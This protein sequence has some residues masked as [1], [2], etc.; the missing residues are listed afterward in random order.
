MITV[1][2]RGLRVEDDRLT[3][4]WF[5]LATPQG[6]RYHTVGLRELAAVPID[7][8]EDPDVL[9]KQ[10]AAV[11][12]MYN[13]EVDFLYAA[14]GIFS[15]DHIGIV[16]FY[17]A[18][19]DGLTE[20]DAAR[21]ALTRLAAVEATLA[22]Y[23]QSKIV[24]PDLRWVQWYL[25]FVAD[26]S[27]NL[28]AIL[29]HPDPRQGKRGL[30]RE[31][32]LSLQEDDDLAAQQNELLFRGLAKLREDFVFQVTA[33]RVG[34][35]RLAHALTQIA[36]VASNVAS[37]RR[38]QISIGLSIGIPLLAAITQGLGGGHTAA[39]SRAHASGDTISEGWGK[40]HTDSW[41]HT[42]SHSISEGGAE[43]WGE[44]HSTSVSHGVTDSAAHTDS[45]GTAHTES[46]GTAHTETHGTAATES[47]ATTNAAGSS[48][49][50]GG[51]ESHSQSQGH[52][53]S[54]AFGRGWQTS[55]GMSVAEGVNTSEGGSRGVT[56]SHSVSHSQNVGGS[57][58]AAPLGIGASAS[59]GEGVSEGIARAEML[60]ENWSAGASEMNTESWG[61]GSS[62]QRTEGVADSV[63][64]V[65][66]VGSSWSAGG[67]ES[68]SETHSTATT[69][70]HSASDTVSKG[71]ADT[72]SKGAADTKGQAISVVE[73][74]SHMNSHSISRTWG[75]AWGEA[76]T[77]GGAD[78][79]SQNWGRAHTDGDVKGVAVGRGGQE[80]FSGGF[81]T[82][83][84]P[85]VSIGRSWQTEDDVAD[86]LT[87]VLRGL[88]GLVNQ[89]SAEGGF[90]T[91]AF[92]I[93]ASERGATAAEALVPQAFHGPSVPTPIL[94]LRPGA[95]DVATLRH[96]ALAFMPVPDLDDG[97]PFGGLLWRRYSTLLHAGQ[98]AALT[99]PGLFEEGTA[100]TVTEAI[101]P[102]MGFYPQLPGDVTVGHQYSPATADLT[103][104]PVNL[105]AARY[106]HTLFAADTGYGKSV[107]A[108][109]LIYETAIR[110]G[111]P[112]VILDWGAGWRQLLHAPG[113]EGQV[114]VLQLWPHAAR[115]LRWNPL[116][117]GR[118]IPPET[119]WRAFADIFGAIARIGVKRQKQELLEALRKV[120][121]RAGVL[122]DDPEVRRDPELGLVR[123][124][125]ESVTGATTGT[126]LGNLTPAQRQALAVYRS[127]Q[128]G[129]ADLY[130]EIQRKLDAVPPRDTMLTGVLEGILF[131]MNALVQGAAA[132]QFAPGDDVIPMEDLIAERGVTIIE[133]GSFLDEFG[134]A[135]LLGWAG[136][137]LYTD[138]VA[139]RVHGGETGRKAQIVFEEANKIFGGIPDGGEDEGGG[140]AYTAQQ[141]GN[142]F[143]DARKYGI[144][145]HVIS[146]SPH[147]IPQDIV[148]SCNNLVV[149]FLK[150]PKDKDLI[151][152]ALAKS[153]KGFTD[154]PWRRFLSDLAV[155]Q[156]VGRFGYAGERHQ[157]RPILFRP[158]MLGA[159]EPSDAEIEERLGTI[160]L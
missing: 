19:G 81:S 146:Q 24:P 68:H 101:P 43:T 149:G 107:A 111:L 147:L 141:F 90:D 39:E 159:P 155:G 87:E 140:P 112:T 21:I 103:G 121:L 82:G 59:Y 133:G 1:L 65:D 143:R 108:I 67:M 56:D 71:S 69:E 134:K 62:T 122:I 152:S 89:A 35:R 96:Y 129:L 61:A 125:E 55:H 109:R 88:E 128:I 52:T 137:H 72:V 6:R 126:P 118:N 104:A 100:V 99:A 148:S 15:P 136:W 85:S 92:L 151:L 130:A 50:A 91:T 83:L 2:D 47:H 13:A 66:A 51:S 77:R 11:R 156:F 54:D 158:M 9:G 145:L 57:V 20:A 48:W 160:R 139:R 17:G 12:G 124:G 5:H 117:I 64:T 105:D 53:E 115:P 36:Q 70:S 33:Q 42:E 25:D 142:M 119:Q 102:G 34:R 28:L 113:L 38:G 45:E 74:E 110:W 8:R 153:E 30:G 7:V 23:P 46:Q 150:N 116:Q 94:T 27:H 86:R 3:Y 138:S 44:A 135:F 127:R 95:A 26:D 78:T 37:R 106:F 41:A 49:S 123:P 40:A 16:Q 144:W 80:G 154:E 29:G 63:G 60:G 157:I 31:G 10:W 97:D 98:V 58:S 75:E 84:L 132:L 14:S 32:A 4:A 73:S 22:N 76:D 79:K 131:R 114:N 93:T 120:Y 18:S